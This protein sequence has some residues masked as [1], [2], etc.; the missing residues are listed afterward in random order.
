M[1]KVNF[2]VLSEKRCVVCNARL[3]ENL[4]KAKPNADM[5]YKHYQMLIRKNPKYPLDD[6]GKAYKRK[7]RDAV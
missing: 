6:I 1:K 3:K 5:C 4:I 2:L 7:L